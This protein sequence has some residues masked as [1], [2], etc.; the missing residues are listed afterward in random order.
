MKTITYIAGPTAAKFHQNQ[1][2]V[3]GLMGPVGCGKSAACIKELYR[4]AT[5][6]AP[7]DENIRLTRM[8][9]IRN[10]YPELRTTTLNTFKQWI[11]EQIAPITYSPVLSSRI[12]FNLED[13]TKVDCEVLF[14]ALDL[15]KDVKKLLSL[16]L[17]AIFL[18]ESRELS[19]SVLTA[20]RER[21]GRYPSFADNYTLENLPEG[22]THPC[23][24]KAI[25]MDTNP[26]D[27][28]HWWYKLAE[29]DEDLLDE[30][31]VDDELFSFFRYPAPL[32]IEKTARSRKYLDNPL[33]ENIQY[34]P[35]GYKYYR[36]M[37]KGNT[38]D[39]INVMVLG[40]YG[41]I[42]TGKPV[43]FEYNDSVHCTDVKPIKSLPIALGWDFGLTPSVVIGQMTPTGQLRIIN[44][45]TS[46]STSVRAF[47]RD[48]VKPF[49]SAN[50]KGFSLAFSVGDPA[51]NNRG[52]GEGRSALGILNDDYVDD[53]E[54]GDIIKPLKLGFETLPA[55]TNDITLRLDAVKMFLTKMVDQGEPGYLIDPKC[56]KL[57]KG[58]IGKYQFKKIQIS[59]QA[60]RF[61]NKPDKNEYSHI[62]DAEQYLALGFIN[63]YQINDDYMV[64]EFTESNRNAYSG[65]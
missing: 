40:Q 15:D 14:L 38:I 2:T 46:V 31:N 17:T 11:P 65:Y 23:T 60:G 36:D 35:G 26:P 63:G 10:T 50:Y 62:S 21:I 48:V 28:D 58:K 49:L 37:I 39:H 27:D 57:R 19:F 41:S 4:L 55:P 18:N 61:H 42:R 34:L 25:I 3:R 53:N 30:D 29:G 22:Q 6:Q 16:E 64:E 43:Y 24:R 32:L 52:E 12:K 59:G 47:A 56:K 9:I 45:L 7:N 1:S 54:D 44:E 13:G 33:A 51:G 8:A 20:A 5:K